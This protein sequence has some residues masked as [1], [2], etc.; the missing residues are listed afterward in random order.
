MVCALPAV[1]VARLAHSRCRLCNVLGRRITLNW[2]AFV[3]V[4]REMLASSK[5]ASPWTVPSFIDASRP[6]KIYNLYP[7]GV[8][9]CPCCNC[10]PAFL[11]R[12]WLKLP[13]NKTSVTLDSDHKKKF[14][15]VI[16]MDEA[17]TIKSETGKILFGCWRILVWPWCASNE[18]Y[19]W[20]LRVTLDD[21]ALLVTK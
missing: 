7:S 9:P 10:T 19:R 5:I 16:D 1:P 3:R 4:A 15:F 2:S 12:S 11:V 21:A 18:V 8:T 6:S 13:C 20:L 17:E 14:F